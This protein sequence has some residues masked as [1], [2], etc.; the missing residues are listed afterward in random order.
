MGKEKKN[1]ESELYIHVLY[2]LFF[3]GKVP[4]AEFEEKIFNY[5]KD[6]DLLFEADGE[7]LESRAT[8]SN[9][10]AIYQR[11]RNLGKSNKSLA[12]TELIDEDEFHFFI[13]GDRF[14]K[15]QELFKTKSPADSNTKETST[16]LSG[17]S[18]L[19]VLLGPPG[20][21]KTRIAKQL[22]NS[23]ASEDNIIF[24]QFHPSYSYEEFIQGE[25][26]VYINLEKIVQVIDGPLMIAYRKATGS[27]IKTKVKIEK[28]LNKNYIRFPL[29]LTEK[30][31]DMTYLRININ[32]TE[33]KLEKFNDL[34]EMS[35]IELIA[36]G[37][38]NAEVYNSK[39]G[40]TKTQQVIIIDELNRADTS[41]VFGELLS[42]LSDAGE[43]CK[44]N[45]RLQ[46]SGEKLAWPA[47]ISILGTM[48]SADRS[49]ATLD[50]AFKRR[51]EFELIQPNPYVFA[52]EIKMDVF[53]EL[54]KT[55]KD[56]FSKDIEIKCCEDVITSFNN[57]FLP[58]L[59]L[60]GKIPSLY[61]LLTTLNN[62]VLK[63]TKFKDQIWDVDKKLIGHSFFI[64]LA[65]L[66]AIE[67]CT[68]DVATE[69]VVIACNKIY[70]DI[71]DME[72]TPQ[73]N[74]ITSENDQLTNEI[75]EDFMRELNITQDVK[76]KHGEV[77]KF[78]YYQKSA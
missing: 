10:E 27:P 16:K 35:N 26:I 31:G 36:E 71:I 2:Y 11:L 3:Y 34:Y 45:I 8:R 30:Y 72:I 38:V 23:I 41:R 67:M 40:D 69:D 63:S 18:F 28:I 24:V 66:L 33:Y 12:P 55:I 42:A 46:Y 29:G 19:K 50:Q 65:R 43:E 44:A 53:N 1:N 15:I 56:R 5:L 54:Q 9:P 37:L 39:W 49:I 7:V 64:K 47:N 58:S 59:S 73:L 4:K 51:F 21:G 13:N 22:A 57:Y 78:K 75:L 60:V 48:N 76:E 52:E 32:N 25:K 62:K 68:P 14:K 70:T 6:N 61:N 17:K 74:S 20:T 77:I